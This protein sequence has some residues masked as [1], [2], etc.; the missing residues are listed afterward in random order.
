[1]FRSQTERTHLFQIVY[2]RRN[3]THENYPM[4]RAFLYRDAPP[5]AA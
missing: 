3:I 4:S 5:P 2:S 1:M